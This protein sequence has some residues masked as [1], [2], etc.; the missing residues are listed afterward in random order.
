MVMTLLRSVLH[1]DEQ[2]TE[3]QKLNRQFFEQDMTSDEENHEFA[4]FIK[5]SEHSSSDSSSSSSFADDKGPQL[6]GVPTPVVNQPRL[7]ML[8][9]LKSTPGPATNLASATNALK[10]KRINTTVN[11]LAQLIVESLNIKAK[12]SK[13]QLETI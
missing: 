2:I 13:E 7:S 6:V 5:P 3:L 11:P 9:K 8:E 1:E 12:V 4:E 10:L